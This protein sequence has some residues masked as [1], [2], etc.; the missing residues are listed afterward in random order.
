MFGLSNVAD[1]MSITY[2]AVYYKNISYK[3]YSKEN[4]EVY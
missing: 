3:Y 2:V 4:V 1:F